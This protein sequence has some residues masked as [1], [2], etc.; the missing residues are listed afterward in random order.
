AGK[1]MGVDLEEPLPDGGLLRVATL[2]MYAP[3]GIR[4][5][6]RG[7]TPDIVVVRTPADVERGVD[8]QLRTAIHLAELH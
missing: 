3:N 2:D 1:V 8:P 5:E 4:L 6:G 7:V